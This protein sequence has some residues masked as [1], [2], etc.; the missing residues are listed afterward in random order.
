MFKNN[1]KPA[2]LYSFL[3]S[4]IFTSISAS[5]TISVDSLISKLSYV[6]GKEKVEVLCELSLELTADA[7]SQSMQYAKDALVLAKSLNYKS[8]VAKAYRC[9][10]S[11]YRHQKDYVNA[12]IY[13]KKGLEDFSVLYDSTYI[14]NSLYNLGTAH[15]SLSQYDS[16]ITYLE[17]A[18]ALYKKRNESEYYLKTLFKISMAY[19]EKSDFKTAELILQKILKS[20][21]KLQNQP[22]FIDVHNGIG[23]CQYKLGAY[24]SAIKHYTVAL[25]T[26]EETRNIIGKASVLDNMC[27]VY[28]ENKDWNQAIKLQKEAIVLAKQTNSV[29][30][31]AQ[32]QHNLGCT[33]YLINEFDS[34]EFDLNE[35]FILF[36]RINNKRGVSVSLTAI[37]KLQRDYKKDYTNALMSFKQALDICEITQ[38]KSLIAENM[39]EFGK[40]YRLLNKTTEAEEILVRGEK[41]AFAIGEK[42]LLSAIYKELSDLYKEMNN[43][44]K[45]FDY[46][47]L[48]T[49]INESIEKDNLV[50]EIERLKYEGE[51]ERKEEELAQKSEEITM[52]TDEKNIQNLRNHLLFILLFLTLAG[53]SFVYVR[54]KKRINREKKSKIQQKQLFASKENHIKTQLKIKDEENVLL[55]NTVL[56]KE[57][58][59]TNLALHLSYNRCFL[60]KITH[61]I[62]TSTS[63]LDN[64]K[65]EKIGNI[66]G[67][68][69]QEI[70]Q[71]KK[72]GEFDLYKIQHHEF[73]QRL[74]EKHP[75]LT[76]KEKQLCVF[77]RLKL[78]S[79][80]IA[81]LLNISPKSVDMSRYRLKKRLN[82]AANEEISSFIVSI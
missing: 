18:A 82:L 74:N 78:S 17:L 71:E 49:S 80:E 76:E 13:L 8:G 14:S 5:E 79:K 11:N 48:Y 57:N 65:E 52:I 54:Q 38:E 66:I 58:E 59:L 25:K 37:G 44:N 24:K 42:K 40:T 4:H 32:Y 30:S 63:T 33:F 39:L 46:L 9:I 72:R 43:A 60:Q 55:K 68:I 28:R 62:K 56:S 75:T 73:L 29:F 1:I 12:I 67:V 64:L 51:I 21:Y 61:E 50:R 6:T 35:A 22:V 15:G 81:S 2:L 7:S 77:L 45:A 20:N 16:A 70:L 31:L 10:E 69:N 23:L 53:G 36:K 26:A 34:A 41:E 27:T 47:Q 3:F 19:F